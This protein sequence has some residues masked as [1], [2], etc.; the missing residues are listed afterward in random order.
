MPRPYTLRTF[1]LQPGEK[2]VVVELLNPDGSSSNNQDETTTLVTI[3][4]GG[5]Y[6]SGMRCPANYTFNVS[7]SP[8]PDTTLTTFIATCCVSEQPRPA[9]TGRL[10]VNGAE[11]PSCEAPT[12][13][14]SEAL[15][16]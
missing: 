15:G 8:L 14:D 4:C 9:L 12:L 2:P 10:G 3:T 7:G 1:P 6:E 16:D 5:L 13:Y 11:C